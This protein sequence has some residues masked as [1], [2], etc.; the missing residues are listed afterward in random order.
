[1]GKWSRLVA[2]WVLMVVASCGD[3]RAAVDAFVETAVD[4]IPNPNP[5][6]GL[7]PI[8]ELDLLPPRSPA[9]VFAHSFEPSISAHGDTV[10]VAYINIADSDPETYPEDGELDKRVAVASSSD[11]GMSFGPARDPMPMTAAFTSTDPVVR[12]GPDGLF[13]LAVLGVNM[14]IDALVAIGESTDGV[15]WRPIASVPAI[16]KEW[17]ALDA[18]SI[19]VA[20]ISTGS[21]YYRFD[22]QGNVLAQSPTLVLNGVVG[23]YV[24]ALGAHIAHVGEQ[25]DV[26]IALWDGVNERRQDGERLPIGKSRLEPFFEYTTTMSLGPTEDGGQWIVRTV[27][28][29]GYPAI[30]L[31]VRHLPDDEG[32]DLP[33]SEPGAH[34]FLPTAIVDEDGRMRVIYYDSSGRRG[35]LRTTRSL[36]TDWSQGFERSTIIDPN[37]CPGDRWVPALGGNPAD[38]GRRLREY[39]DVALT[40]RRVHVAWTSSPQSPSRVHTAYFDY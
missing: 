23:M 18:T 27:K 8:I 21:S 39:I 22:L 34:A 17:I 36:S 10:V 32:T 29:N 14:N 26:T 1:M 28:R 9:A 40:S 37:A 13:R 25:E 4:A 5:T 15:T 38:G 7:G 16:D 6:P 31:R 2:C 3:N 35:V 20:F 33:I 19:W 11:R 24:D 30:V 12:T